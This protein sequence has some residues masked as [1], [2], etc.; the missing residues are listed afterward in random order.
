MQ[1]FFHTENKS[2]FKTQ[3][4]KKGGFFEELLSEND[5]ETV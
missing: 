2:N 1:L 3:A 5:L 4:A